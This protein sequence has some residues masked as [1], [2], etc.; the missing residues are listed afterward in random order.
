MYPLLAWRHPCGQAALAWLL[1]FCLQANGAKHLA[2]SASRT[3]MMLGTLML[4]AISKQKPSPAFRRTSATTPVALRLLGSSS[5]SSSSFLFIIIFTLA[6]RFISSPF[7]FSPSSLFFLS[8]FSFS[9][10]PFNILSK[11]VLHIR[12]MSPVLLHKLCAIISIQ[13]EH[14]CIGLG[15]FVRL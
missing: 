15:I 14:F 1:L 6:L 3:K 4:A 11:E 12:D 10:R 13:G 8:L 7:S 9:Y 5:S 2:A